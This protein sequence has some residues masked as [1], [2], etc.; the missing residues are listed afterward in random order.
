MF[1]FPCTFSSSEWGDLCAG[2]DKA[3][4]LWSIHDHISS[5][6]SEPGSGGGSA[7]HSSKI[8]GSNDKLR[9]SPSVEPRGVYKGHEDTVEDVQFCPSRYVLINNQIH[10]ISSLFC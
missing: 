8:G 5:L 6:A 10:F 7:K 3:V 1:V 2:K 4:I 9:D